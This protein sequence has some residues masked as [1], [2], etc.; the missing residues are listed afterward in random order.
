MRRSHGQQDPQ[1]LL[2]EGDIHRDG[3]VL[4]GGVVLH[5]RYAIMGSGR[6]PC[7]LG[8][9]FTK[10]ALLDLQA[11]QLGGP[12]RGGATPA[13][14]EVCCWEGH[15]TGGPRPCDAQ[16]L[17]PTAT[18]LSCPHV[19]VLAGGCGG[20]DLKFFFRGRDLDGMWKLL[21]KLKDTTFPSEDI[22]LCKTHTV[23]E[24]KLL[25]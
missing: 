25:P 9:P 22:G 11:L 16:S 15:H 7:I 20:D 4:A 23:A 1:G 10:A 19:D 5:G 3:K 21:F 6:G 13:Q 14:G 24:V 18:S 2:A 12:G 17:N 8:C